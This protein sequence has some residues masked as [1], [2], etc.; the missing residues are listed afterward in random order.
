MNWGGREEEGRKKRKRKQA[1]E[2]MLF[3]PAD[4]PVMRFL[5]IISITRSPA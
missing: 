1:E 4:F 3:D 5:K 2:K